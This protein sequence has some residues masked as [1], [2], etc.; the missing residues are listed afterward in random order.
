MYMVKGDPS[1]ELRRLMEL[2]MHRY[3]EETEP[4]LLDPHSRKMKD[5]IGT[6]IFEPFNSNFGHA[7]P[8]FIEFC[9]GLGIPEV[10]RIVK[11]WEDRFRQEFYSGYTF[12]NGGMASCFAAAQIAERARIINLDYEYIYQCVLQELKRVHDEYNSGGINYEDM[13]QEFMSSNMNG[14]LAFNESD[15]VSMGPRGK[16]LIVRAE[17]NEGRVWI[18]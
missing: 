12:W 5:D 16:D 14:I 4:T 18:S 17:V 1:G 8:E 13:L 3:I 2:D 9:F 7:G 6:P 15:K 11:K 10:Q